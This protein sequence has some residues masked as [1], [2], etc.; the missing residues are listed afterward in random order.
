MKVH[1]MQ[2]G[3]RQGYST[4][5]HLLLSDELSRRG[6]PISIFLDLR[7]A[8]D[9]VQWHCLA[10]KLTERNCPKQQLA[11]ISSLMF[12]PCS[13]ELYVNRTA[14]G[15]I[16]SSRGLF[17]GSI[18]SPGL[19]NIYIDDLC[20]QLN[21]ISPSLFF[22]D[23]ILLK[24]SDPV[25]A[26]RALSIC[27]HWSTVNFIDWGVVKC[28]VVGSNEPFHISNEQI[29]TLQTYKY[30]G[31]PHLS[32]RVDW[33]QL[34]DSNA[35]KHSRLIIA[36]SDHAESWSNIARLTI[37][38]TFIRPILDYCLSI[39][40]CWL[41]KHKNSTDLL[42]SRTK[43][44]IKDAFSEGTAFVCSSKRTTA[45]SSLIIGTG[46]HLLRLKILGVGLTKHLKEMA[47]SNPLKKYLNGF[48]N[49]KY[50]IMDVVFNHPEYV[51]FLAFRNQ[52]YS[53]PIELRPR[54]YPFQLFKAHLRQEWL[55]NHCSK[56][57]YYM[58]FPISGRPFKYDSSVTLPS[59]DGIR[60]RGGTFRTRSTCPNCKQLFNRA[61][62]SR[63]NLFKNLPAAIKLEQSQEFQASMASLTALYRLKEPND[64]FYYTI[65]DY[66]LNFETPSNQAIFLECVSFLKTRLSP[67]V[68]PAGTQTV[69]P[70]STQH[71]C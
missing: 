67:A 54:G 40:A 27:S 59:A 50:F 12:Q 62:I 34:V 43:T 49:S 30:L 68:P 14:V 2:A 4:I 57:R 46:D 63:C 21:H 5:T 22:A 37:W 33:Q 36:L 11:I 25:A 64:P 61:H 15:Q 58:I 10:K 1:D 66:L 24:H 29:P 6:Y 8:Y 20:N 38:R 48:K 56:Q 42:V 41:N 28:G 7:A 55:L 69:P 23:D 71:R 35:Q 44:R 65:L 31:V 19:F 45:I 60:W 18:L 51:S 32:N 39:V 17:Q 52:L 9:S 3:F 70:D 13:M 47:A 16:T 26:Q 53:M